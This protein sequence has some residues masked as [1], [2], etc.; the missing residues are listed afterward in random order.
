MPYY[1]PINTL[2]IA[3]PK[4][5]T[6]SITKAL[7]IMGKKALLT[8]SEK[9]LRLKQIQQQY[10]EHTKGII[11]SMVRDPWQ[12]TVSVY[13]YTHISRKPIGKTNFNREFHNKTFDE[14]LEH[15]WQKYKSNPNKWVQ[16]NFFTLNGEI[17]P[18]AIIGKLCE[19]QKFIDKIAKML[20]VPSVKM[21]H[22]NKTGE[23]GSYKAFYNTNRIG[24]VAEMNKIDI[25]EFDF[26]YDF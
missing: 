10:P 15:K 16:K 22:I 19:A 7:E 2:F 24:I 13:R 26:K 6:S 1:P 18:N 4:T 14:W 17:P 8:G 3:V 9:H 11:C 21:P 25:E 5:G 12:R 20:K 23:V